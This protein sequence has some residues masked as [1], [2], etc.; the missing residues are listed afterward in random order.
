MK[1]ISF[2]YRMTSEDSTGSND[3]AVYNSGLVIT[4]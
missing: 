1:V 2:A 3:K 4:P